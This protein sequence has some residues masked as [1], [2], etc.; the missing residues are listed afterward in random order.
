MAAARAVAQLLAIAWAGWA[1]AQQV[2]LDTSAVVR[3]LTPAADVRGT[4]DYPFDA[5]KSGTDG[6][7]KVRLSFSA[8]D[9]PPRVEVL[10][11][12]GAFVD[13]VKQHVREFRVPCLSA[14][15]APA[16]LTQEYVFRRDRRQVLWSHLED[17]ADARRREMLKCV[18]HASGQKSPDYPYR[19]R[20]ESVQGRV[21][22][23]LVFDAADRPPKATVHARKNARLLE[24]EVAQWVEDLRMPCHTGSPLA[25]DWTFVFRFEGDAAYGFGGVSLRALL[26]SIK[27]IQRQTVAFDFNTM[28]CPFD[29]RL[30]YLQPYMPNS[31]G[32]VGSHDAARRPF[33]DWLSKAELNLPAATQDAVFADFADLHIPCLKINLKP[34]EKP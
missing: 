28:G 7:V 8:V 21:L 34:Q 25:A 5:L 1:Q 14:A 17:L 26:A 13:A 30:H 9:Q 24:R 19:A 27:D 11:G 31:V 33:L 23:R 18:A 29:L 2:A 10:E 6:R 3:C 20:Q 32:Q 4:P 15:D 16:Q 22:A 12:D